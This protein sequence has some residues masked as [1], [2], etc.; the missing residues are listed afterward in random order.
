MTT[1]KRERERERERERKGGAELSD[2][3]RRNSTYM[4][5]LEEVL[6]GTVLYVYMAYIVHASRHRKSSVYGEMTADCACLI[7]RGAV[8]ARL[9]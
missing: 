4:C 8:A 6:I 7:L 2:G 9:V 3:G 1:T 5:M